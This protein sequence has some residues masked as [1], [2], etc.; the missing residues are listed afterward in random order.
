MKL[1]RE[2]YIFFKMFPNPTEEDIEK[3]AAKMSMD[4]EGI[5]RYIFMM[6]S[7]FINY[8][9]S[10]GFDGEYDPEQLRMGIEVEFEHTNIPILSEK[11]ARDHLA[12]IPDYYTRLAKMEKEAGV[13]EG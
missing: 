6:L 10:R 11:I 8:G 1:M 3:F 9:R 2:I 13:V 4:E 7:D 12:E 5:E